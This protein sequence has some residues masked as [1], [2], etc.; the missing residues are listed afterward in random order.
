MS[1]RPRA[2]VILAAVF[3]LGC[4]V[5][6]AGSLLYSRKALQGAGNTSV[7]RNQ[8]RQR[9]PELLKLTPE[10][11]SRFREVMAESR[12]QLEA[13]RNEQSSRIAAIRSE[14]NSKLLAILDREQQ[15]KLADFLKSARERRERTRRGAGWGP[16]R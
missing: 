13:I 2:L 14:T 11:E 3:L 10:Q 7:V 9:L 15:Q 16:L 1:D 8:G 12:K 5:G 4:V 6:T